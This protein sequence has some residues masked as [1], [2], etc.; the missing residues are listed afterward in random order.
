MEKYLK[1]ET[2]V[3]CTTTIAASFFSFMGLFYSLKFLMDAFLMDAFSSLSGKKSKLFEIYADM[4]P[5][6]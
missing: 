2:F 6:Q 1:D 3:I 4:K 5:S